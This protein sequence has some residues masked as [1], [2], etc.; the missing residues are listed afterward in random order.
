MKDCMS[1]KGEP[2]EDF[3]KRHHQSLVTVAKAIVGNIYAE[4]V[5]QDSWLTLLSG[6]T[7]IRNIHSL[8]AWLFRVVVNKSI[9]KKKKEQK[10][11]SFQSMQFHG[12][13][14][15]NKNDIFD[16]DSTPENIL[17]FLESIDNIEHVWL[18]LPFA[19]KRAAQMSFGGNYSNE[20]IAKA[21]GISTNNCK[22]TIHRAKTKLRNALI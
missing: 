8:E 17:S 1:L 18:G 13:D 7:E 22:V 21:L 10:L 2:I 4:E 5:V 16:Y 6:T 14:Q 11:T 9:N 12:E 3:V 15:H 20:E 19:Q